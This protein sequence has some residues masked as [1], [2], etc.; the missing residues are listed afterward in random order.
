MLTFNFN[1]VF[2]HL[3][4]SDWFLCVIYI[5]FTTLK[6]LYFS[7]LSAL[8]PAIWDTITSKRF[9]SMHSMACRDF[10]RFSWMKIK[11][12][13]SIQA[14]WKDCRACSSCNW[15]RTKLKPLQLM[16]SSTWQDSKDCKYKLCGEVFI[17]IEMIRECVMLKGCQG[18]IDMCDA[19][20]KNEW[21]AKLKIIPLIV[22]A[23][24]HWKVIE[25]QIHFSRWQSQILFR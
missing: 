9:H 16:R 6:F 23:W 18:A 7:L 25:F 11:S 8:V 20:A 17:F 10:I 19:K 22:H 12:P 4:S 1:S 21:N 15:M 24:K 3:W 13:Q 14:R 5:H 2:R